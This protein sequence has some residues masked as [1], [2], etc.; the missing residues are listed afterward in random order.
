MRMIWTRKGS[1]LNLMELFKRK[2]L[3][4]VM[5][6]VYLSGERHALQFLFKD[7]NFPF[8]FINCAY[9]KQVREAE[10]QGL[11]FSMLITYFTLQ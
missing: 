6:G 2:Y 1:K 9:E 7:W 3:C 5:E 8:T 10:K 4:V 11:E